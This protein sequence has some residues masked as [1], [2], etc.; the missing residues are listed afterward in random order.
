MRNLS[1]KIHQSG[2]LNILSGGLFCY[3]ILRNKTEKNK[4]IFIDFMFACDNASWMEKYWTVTFRCWL[5]GFA[6][7]YYID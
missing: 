7:R 3:N 5:L 6:R 4:Q 1:F 2:G